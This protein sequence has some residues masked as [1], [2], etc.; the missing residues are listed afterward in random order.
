[1]DKDNQM[2]FIITEN[3]DTADELQK[4]GFQIVQTIGDSWLFLN[5]K[6]KMMF[7]DIKNNKNLVF[8]YTNKMM[9]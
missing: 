2:N 1:M 9:F 5:D 7:A 6:K 8:A 4:L 3:K